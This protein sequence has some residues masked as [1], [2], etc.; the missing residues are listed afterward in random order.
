MIIGTA[1]HID[2]GKTTLVRALTGV[3]TDRLPEEKK[4]GITIELG[5]APLALPGI[6][7]A[8]V[9]DVPGH[10]AFVRTMLAGAT[11]VDL[12]LLV[13]AADEGMMPQTREHLAILSLLAVKGGVVALTKTDIVEDEWLG[14]VR[15]DVRAA[16]ADSPLADAAIVPVSAASGAGLDA[17]RAALAAAA[18][19]VPARDPA[20]LFRMPVDRSFTVRGTGTVVTGTVW[21][22]SL[23]SDATIRIMPNGRTARVRGIQSHGAAAAAALPGARVALS[24]AGVERDDVPRGSWIIAEPEWRAT[25]ILR[26]DVAL[27]E[28]ASP[29]GPRTRVRFHLGTQD[30]GARVVS[31]GGALTA[32]AVRGTRIL[33]DEPVLARG[34]DRFVLR[35]PSPPA[36]IGGGVVADPLPGV[37]RARPWAPGL[38]LG[39]RLDAV[40]AEAAGQGVPVRSLAVRLGIAPRAAALLARSHSRA[41]TLIDGRMVA[42][43]VVEGATA[44]AAQL[45]VEHHEQFPL[46]PGMALSALRSGLAVGDAVAELV[47]RELTSAGSM[48]IDGATVRQA[49]FTPSLDGAAASIA[50]AIERALR[51]GGREPPSVSE[52]AVAIGADPRPVLRFL[53][54]SGAVGAVEEDRYYRAEDLRGMVDG[55]A[56]AMVRGRVYTPAELRDITGLSRKY[57][58]PFLEYCDRRGITAR[59]ESGRVR[60][61]T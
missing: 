26:A 27:L 48:T 8:G 10:E 1:G 38:S 17:L 42:R 46:D 19:R 15:E 4:R 12:A 34:G 16:L 28:D 33:L 37:A 5:F 55:L 60:A 58:I 9:V 39:D 47:I 50:A 2:H 25:Q 22:G 3:D 41:I 18:A 20:D 14:L 51:A 36:T 61:G 23:D 59:Q 54:R 49:G 30:V 32:G 57:L 7:V 29:L 24:I 21:S 43:S 45:V 53:E 44:R 13:V 56:G 35:L 6:G 52:L 31:T 40:L 11:G